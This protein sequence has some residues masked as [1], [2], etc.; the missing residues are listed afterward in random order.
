MAGHS[1]QETRNPFVAFVAPALV[2]YTLFW[3]VPMLG[4]VGIS[5]THW[6]GIGFVTMRWAG[7]ANYGQLWRDPIFWGSLGNNLV[8][9]A[10]ALG[11]IVVSA[12]VVA[13]VLNARPR[14]HSAFAT[15]L[16]MPIVLSNVIIGLLFTLLLSPTAGVVGPDTQWLGDP[17]TALW[18]VLVA[19]VWRD[20]GFSVLLFLAAL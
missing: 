8:F 10:A 6:D 2:F 1:R 9:V 15:I 16:F 14:G 3:I 20:L 4:A 5:L 17:D 12:L 7:L 19:Y 13:L 11:I 18:S